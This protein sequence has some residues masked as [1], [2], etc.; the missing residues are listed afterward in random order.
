MK[1]AQYFA[2]FILCFI[3]INLQSEANC[4]KDS[5]VVSYFSESQ[6]S[7]TTRSVSIDTFDLDIGVK[8][9]CI[10]NMSNAGIWTNYHCVQSFWKRTTDSLD[11][12]GLLIESLTEIGSPAGWINFSR[13]KYSYN[14]NN[15]LLIEEKQNWN[16][17]LWETYY[18][19]ELFYDVQNNLV[20]ETVQS[21]SGGSLINEWKRTWA[22]SSSQLLSRTMEKGDGAGWRN[23]SAFTFSYDSN[24][25]RDSAW[26]QIWDTI[27]GTW[28]NYGPFRAPLKT[29]FYFPIIRYWS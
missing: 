12:Q 5:V 27:N 2:S 22:Y 14:S 1:P 18:L 13:V 11:N 3:F 28:N 8:A 9:S 16:G 17:V 4:R 24:G 20:E 6:N 19:H 21:D 25:M 23:D 10:K 7:G 15:Q 29:H 26:I